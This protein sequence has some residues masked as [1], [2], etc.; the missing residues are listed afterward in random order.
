VITIIVLFIAGI[1][2]IVACQHYVREPVMRIIGICAGAACVVI[3][4]YFLL[5]GLLGGVSTPHLNSG[6]QLMMIEKR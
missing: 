6:S 4:A 1:A 5:T 3:A 2:I